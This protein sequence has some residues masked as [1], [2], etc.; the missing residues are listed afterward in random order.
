MLAERSVTARPTP[1]TELGDRRGCRPAVMPLRA[2]V[3]GYR[4][5]GRGEESLVAARAAL[6]GVAT[7]IPRLGGPGRRPAGGDGMPGEGGAAEVV[8]EVVAVG[9]A[10][11]LVQYECV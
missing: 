6:G 10:G 8:G 9:L 4:L 7:G 1:G 2:A 11:C 3:R 5:D